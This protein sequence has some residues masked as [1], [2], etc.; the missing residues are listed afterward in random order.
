MPKRCDF[1]LIGDPHLTRKFEFGVPLARRGERERLLF[2]DFEKRLYEG[3][4]RIIIMVGD[5]LE[6]PICSL[7]DAYT[8]YSM[9]LDA[10]KNQPQR[11][12]LLLAG[13]H[14]ISPQKDNPGAFDILK[15]FDERYPNLRVIMKPTV[16]ERIALFPW[17]WDRTALEQLEEVQ[18]GTFDVAVGHWDLVAYDEMHMDHYCPAA[19]LVEMGAE[20]L[21]SGHWHVAGDYK[22]D[23][24]TVHCTGSMQPM[25]HAEDPDGKLY[26]TMDYKDY[27]EADP[28]TLKDKYIRVVAEE[29]E[30]VEAPTDCLGFKVQRARSDDYEYDYGEVEIEDFSSKEVVKKNLKKHKVPESVEDFIMERLNVAD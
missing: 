9:V 28:E 27:L 7:R 16:I 14:D 13:N 4:E 23:G 21:Y 18:A 20:S 5:L 24:V 19:E 22:V 8:I 15:L 12:I 30:E 2:E 6:K 3:D 17:E 10:A 1:R 29:G 11:L 26:V 25:T